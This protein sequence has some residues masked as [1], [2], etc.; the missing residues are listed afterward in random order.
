MDG[1]SLTALTDT[2]IKRLTID[3]TSIDDPKQKSDLPKGTKIAINWYRP[4]SHN[5]WEFE[6]RSQRGGFFNWYAYQP[7][8]EIRGVSFPGVSNSNQ[9]M[10]FLDVIAWAEGTDK[11]IGD[12]MRSGY[13]IIFTFDKFSNFSDHPRRLRHGGGLSSDAAG[14]YQFLSTTWDF[15][16]SGLGLPDFSPASQDKAAIQLI[17]HRGAMSDIEAGRVEAAC[18]KL[19]WEWASLPPGRYGQ[20]IISYAKVKQL[21]ELAGG[22]L[23]R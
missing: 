4:S 7:H 5:H 18:D 23:H 3:S 8:V 9:V 11:S 15:V 19:S 2:V 13:D 20:P 14:R 16:A 17:K 21:F 12:N 10:A 1:L 6:L 22:H